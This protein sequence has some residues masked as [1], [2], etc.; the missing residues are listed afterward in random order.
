MSRQTISNQKISRTYKI[1][2]TSEEYS[3]NANGDSNNIISRQ[4]YIFNNSESPVG[5]MQQRSTD[6]QSICTCGKWKIDNNSAY[7]GTI[8]TNLKSDENYTCDEGKDLSS[9]CNCYKKNMNK[10]SKITKSYNSQNIL[11]QD[12][13]YC[14]CEENNNIIPSSETQENIIDTN[15]TSDVNI[16]INTNNNISKKVCI[17]GKGE[18]EAEIINTAASNNEL[19]V[20]TIETKDEE[21]KGKVEVE[22]VEEEKVEEENIEEED[23]KEEK[24][25]EENVEEENIEEE[26]VEEEKEEEKVEEEEEEKEE[27]KVEE[28]EEKVEE[29]KVEEEEEKEEKE[30]KVEEEEKVEKEEKIEEEKKIREE[31]TLI[32]KEEIIE[33]KITQINQKKEIITWTGEIFI[34]IIERL[35]YLAAE[36]PLL[37]VQFLND[38]IID[39]TLD[40]RPIQVLIPIP[41][42]FIQ[43]QGEIQVLSE[44]KDKE[45]ELCPENVELLNISKAYSIQ[46]PAFNNLEIENSEMFIQSQPKEL[47]LFMEQYSLF[48]KGESKPPLQIE[49]YAWDISSTGKMW[50]GPIKPVRTNKLDIEEEEKKEDWN[51]LVKKENVEKFE[52]EKGQKYYRFKQIELGDNEVILLKPA[53][54]VLKDYTQTEESNVTVGGKGFKPRVWEPE[55]FLANS[56]TIERKKSVPKLDITSS[57]MEMPPERKRRPN[58]NLVNTPSLATSVNYL[59]AKEKILEP[60]NVNPLSII[61]EDKNKDKWKMNVKKQSGIKLAFDKIPKKF[62]LSIKKEINMFFEREVDDVIVNDDYNN[63]AGPQTRPI[64][65]TV[66]KVNEEEETSSVSSYDVFKNLIIQKSSLNIEFNSQNKDYEINLINKGTF[67]TGEYSYFSKMN[68]GNK[69]RT[70]EN[71][72]KSKYD[73]TVKNLVNQTKNLMGNMLGL[74]RKT[75]NNENVREDPDVKN[76]LKV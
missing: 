69:S 17:C 62:D 48:C 47:I 5:N 13:Y 1:S 8:Q 70:D 76:F 14:N 55:P 6:N 18:H 73:T 29:E 28:E 40:N 75:K 53:K 57:G 23:I 24:V 66:I 46:V 65:V 68:K 7:N 64:I 67:G 22:K 71:K 20:E 9:L 43:K 42:N 37:H 10:T 26:N 25:E 50:S 12:N 30:E 16:N 59:L 56:M 51:N 45:E 60:Q 36:P 41:E 34:Q 49:N 4:N 27:E 61:E 52:F 58:W 35:Q 39:R 72:Q 74:N 38:V 44:Q 32:Q 19:Q 21:E 11:I 3:S 2:K 31:Q 54:R 33:S 15:I 63:I